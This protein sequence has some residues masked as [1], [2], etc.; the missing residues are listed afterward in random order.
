MRTDVLLM[1]YV[2]MRTARLLDVCRVMMDN[3]VD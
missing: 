1:M 2:C 3:W